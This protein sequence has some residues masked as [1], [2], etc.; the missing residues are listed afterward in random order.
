M[1]RNPTFVQVLANASG[2]PVEVAPVVE[3]TTLGA[4]F[5]AG[6]ATGVWSDLAETSAHWAPS[7]AVE[8]TEALDRAAWAAAV[9]RATSWIPE[10]STLDF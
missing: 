5:L 6:I 10:L 9:A 8:P 3:A 7:S 1:S 4:G 2:K